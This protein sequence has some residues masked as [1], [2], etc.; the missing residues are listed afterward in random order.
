[1]VDFLSYYDIIQFIGAS[2]A[3]TGKAPPGRGLYRR[4]NEMKLHL[5]IILFLVLMLLS[6]PKAY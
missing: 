5:Q 4:E 3:D 6:I 1:M 2:G